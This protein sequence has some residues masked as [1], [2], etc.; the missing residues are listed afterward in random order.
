MDRGHL[1]ETCVNYNFIALMGRFLDKRS[2]FG[3]GR[4]LGH[5][6]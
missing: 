6:R 5:L 1:L 2:L 3:S 4:L